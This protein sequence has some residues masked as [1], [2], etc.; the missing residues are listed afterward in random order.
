[1]T[2]NLLALIPMLTLVVACDPEPKADADAANEDAAKEEPAQEEAPK[3]EPAKDEPAAETGEAAPNAGG[4]NPHPGEPKL[5]CAEDADCVTTP[6]TYNGDGATGE[7]CPGCTGTLSNKEYAA[8]LQTYCDNVRQRSCAKVR[9][10]KLYDTEIK[11]VE[12]T[13]TSVG[14]DG[15]K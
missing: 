5:T 2:R 14:V 13:C 10:E 4:D 1:M 3:D 12:G 6:L 7:C 8:E 15:E 11:C 9:C